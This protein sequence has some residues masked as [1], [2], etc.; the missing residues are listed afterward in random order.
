MTGS[1]CS[2]PGVRYCFLIIRKC[3]E[4][5]LAWVSGRGRR[6]RR[7]DAIEIGLGLSWEVGELS[8]HRREAGRL[9][10]QEGVRSPADF[11]VSFDFVNLYGVFIRLSH[12]IILT[13]RSDAER[14]GFES[15]SC[16]GVRGSLSVEETLAFF[17][18]SADGL[19]GLNRSV[20]SGELSL[21]LSV[22]SIPLKIAGQRGKSAS[23]V[24]LLLVDG[25]CVVGPNSVVAWVGISISLAGIN[26]GLN[27][28]SE[29][30][31]VIVGEEELNSTVGEASDELA[32]SGLGSLESVQVGFETR[33]FL[34]LAG[35]TLAS[36]NLSLR[37]G[38]ESGI[39]SLSSCA[40]RVAWAW[41]RRR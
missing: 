10:C 16:G 9:V 37:G 22:G 25:S 2:F 39:F 12:N 20:K 29:S 27:L 21:T 28:S 41:G 19:T 7:G 31:V 6:R 15:R 14:E 34:C 18:E 36:T 30:G 40:V 1:A 3:I 13:T 4:F 32:I 23:D 33:L 17:G 38:E 26:C 5:C 11:S 35:F 24:L 8:H